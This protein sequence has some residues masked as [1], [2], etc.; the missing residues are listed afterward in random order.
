MLSAV[1]ANV[2][3]RQCSRELM[4]AILFFNSHTSLYISAIKIPFTDRYISRFP[5]CIYYYKGIPRN[6]VLANLVMFNV[7]LSLSGTL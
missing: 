6:L 2:C 3:S 7:H 5:S 4:H 1:I